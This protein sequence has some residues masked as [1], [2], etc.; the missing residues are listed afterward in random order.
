MFMSHFYQR[1]IQ[2]AA[3]IAHLLGNQAAKVGP[4][5]FEISGKYVE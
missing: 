1:Q 5:F 3:Q 2:G 4:K